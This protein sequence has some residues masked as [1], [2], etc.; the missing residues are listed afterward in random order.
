MLR[1]QA[2]L[3]T[4]DVNGRVI[5]MLREGKNSH[6]SFTPYSRRESRR[7]VSRRLYIKEDSKQQ[8]RTYYQA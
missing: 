1:V 3:K 5:Y 2:C 8:Q 4:I 6:K 7:H